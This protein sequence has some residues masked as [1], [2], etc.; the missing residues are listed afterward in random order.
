MPPPD[1]LHEALA[2]TYPPRGS[3]DQLRERLLTVL[4]DASTAAGSSFFTDADLVE[5]TGL[6]R[7]TVRRAMDRLQAEGW[8][9]REIGRGT[10]VGPRAVGA[11]A[12]PGPE[13]PAGGDAGRALRR[14]AVASFR[15]AGTTTLETDWYTA[16]LLQGLDRTCHEHHVAVELLGLTEM[17]SDVLVERIR[18][19]RPHV[20]VC[21]APG[22]TSVEL[23]LEA[24]RCGIR[25]VVV[26]SARTV[27]GVPAL[28]ENNHQGARVAVE[29]LASLGHERIGFLNRRL[30]AVW[31]HER[32]HGHVE[33][34]RALGLPD[35][36][37][38][39]CWFAP[40]SGP[41]EPTP[42]DTAAIARW[43]ERS[44]ATAVVCGTFYGALALEPAAEL[45]GLAVP[46]DL[47]VLAFDDHPLLRSAFGGRSV[48][49]LG[50]PL[51]E[52]GGM[53]ARVAGSGQ[54]LPPTTFF[55][56][57]FIRGGT[58]AAPLS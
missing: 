1:P 28:V 58:T 4:R 34:Q 3:A 10:F 42:D 55:D 36:E 13:Q 21:L 51:G 54:D 9:Q 49:R 23:L 57:D 22:P 37:G 11:A 35:D 30:G 2:A 46:A 48:T 29:H 56:F 16:A 52:M 53:I 20:L 5:M 44:G 38:L 43:L 39:T 18:R 41:W 19:S 14:V 17:R 26:A 27:D 32:Q 31:L 6:S 12:T 15:L 7:S 33:A 8:V 47:S 24:Q 25:R 45:A 40:P 50:V